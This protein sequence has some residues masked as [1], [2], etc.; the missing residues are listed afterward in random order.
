MHEYTEQTRKLAERILL[1]LAKILKLDESY[2]SD[3]LG[4]AAHMHVRFNHYPQCS[5]PDLVMGFNP[6]TDGTVIT[7]L[8][9][10]EEVEG[11]Q[12]LKDGN[13]FR[14]PIIPHALVINVGN[15]LQVASVESE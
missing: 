10:D 13:W 2:F 4:D 6:H 12:V 7:L 3:Q 9:P 8:L 15:T 14:V 1:A 11:L 5:R